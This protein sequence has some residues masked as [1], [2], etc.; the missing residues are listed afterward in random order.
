MNKRTI[1]R[2]NIQNMHSQI[3][4]KKRWKC[5]LSSGF[6]SIK[7]NKNPYYATF[8]MLFMKSNPG[9]TPYLYILVT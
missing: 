1:N 2:I 7:R 3:V 5:I 6:Y 9:V 4:Y 8:I